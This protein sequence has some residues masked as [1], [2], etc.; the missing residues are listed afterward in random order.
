MRL[1]E[2]V[3]WAMHSCVVLAVLPRGQALPAARLA[4]FHGVPA[5]YMAKHLQALSQAGIVESVP[6]RRGGYRLGRPAADI[7]LLEIV[8]AVEG[9]TGSFRCT[10]IRRRGPSAS[11][12][13]EYGSPCS[14]S[15]AMQRADDAWRAELERQTLASLLGEV[16]VS[17]SPVVAT[18]AATWI[19]EV[20]R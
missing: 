7:T 10:E 5:A 4:E 3:E 14:I 18:K 9:G 11:P 20:A 8:D 15:V 2:G 12:A 17:I 1:G 16:A 6:G 19:Q 13:Q